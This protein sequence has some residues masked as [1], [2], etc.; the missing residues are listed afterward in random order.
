MASGE[1]LNN[2]P[3]DLLTPLWTKTTPEFKDEK[4]SPG[5]TATKDGKSTGYGFRLIRCGFNQVFA[6]RL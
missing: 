2:L 5:E 1:S 3:T 4:D 6:K